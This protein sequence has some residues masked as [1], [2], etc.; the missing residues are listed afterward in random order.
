[1][2]FSTGASRGDLPH[3]HKEGCTFFVTFCL[4]DAGQAKARIRRSADRN[5]DAD[6][7]ARR[8]EPPL[9]RGSCVLRR[10]EI[11]KLVENALLF[12]QGERYALHSWVI[13][14]NHVHVV[15][16]PSPEHPLSEILHSWKSY[17][18]NQING[19]L[20]RSG[21]L[22]EEESFDHVVRNE[23]SLIKFTSY[24]DNNPVAA[25]ICETARNW[26]FGS[27]RFGRED[28]GNL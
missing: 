12:F 6:E 8:S 13:M 11:A 15:V 2:P 16:T 21:R 20:G 18:S 24:I 27:A 3:L 28:G 7:A 23:E 1:L 14:P 9:T 26:P 5:P 25:G 10:P 22:W 17:T 4:H 19:T